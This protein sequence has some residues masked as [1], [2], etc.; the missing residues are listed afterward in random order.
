MTLIVSNHAIERYQER[1]EPVSEACARE[2]L[3]TPAFSA[4][5]A[6]GAKYVKLPTGARA[7]VLNNTVV[8][9]LEPCMG[10]AAHYADIRGVV[11]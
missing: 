9:V 8:T 10:V 7:V 2:R 1:V 3:S 11:R 6:F 5:A 4:A